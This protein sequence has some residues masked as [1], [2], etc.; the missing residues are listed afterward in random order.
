M[1]EEVLLREE[2]YKWEGNTDTSGKPTQGAG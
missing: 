1:H 2:A